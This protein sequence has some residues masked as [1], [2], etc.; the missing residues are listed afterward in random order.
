[1]S[2]SIPSAVAAIMA[3]AAVSVPSSGEVRFNRDVRPILSDRCYVCHGPDSVNRRAGLRFDQEQSAKSALKSG[4]FAIVPGKP[5]ESE[6]YRRIISDDKIKRMPPAYAGHAKLPDPQIA[7]L[8]E[9]I[10]EGAKY[11]QHWSFTPPVRAAGGSIDSIVRARLDREGLRM[12][13]EADKAT[14]IRRVTLDLTGLPPSIKDVD[15]FLHDSSPHAYERVVD[16]LLGSTEYAE[17]MAIRWLEAARYSDTNGYQSDGPREMWR[18][19]DWVIDAFAKNMPFDEFTIEQIA[20]DLLPNRTRDQQIATAFNRNH[21]TSAEGGIVEEEFRSGYVSDRAETTGTVWLGLTVGC[22]KCHDHKYD[23]ITQRDYYSLYSFFNNMHE[24]GLVYNFGNEEPMLKAPTPEMES[25]LASLDAAVNAKQTAWD[26]LSNR[27]MLE[28]KAWTKHA[29][30]GPPLDWAP[31]EGISLDRPESTHFD[32]KSQVELSPKIGKF[33]YQEPFSAAAWI[34]PES[35]NGAILSRGEDYLEGTGYYLLLVNGKLRFTATLRYTDISLRVETEEPVTLNQWQHVAVT[36]NGRRKASGVHLYINGEERKMNVLFD[37]FT[38]PYSSASMPFRIGGGAGFRFAGDIRG[39]RVYLSELSRAEASTLPIEK[40]IDELARQSQRTSAEG[41]KLHLCFLDQFASSEIKQT[42]AALAAALKER[43]KFY[44]SI[45]TVMVMVEGPVRQAHI[46]KRG[47][48]DAPGDPVSA[49]TPKFLTPFKAGWPANR[50][51]LARWLVDRGNPLTARVT[52]NRFWQMFFGIGLVK[53]TEDFGSQGDW[54]VQEE[55]LDWLAVEFMDSGWDVKH[56]L[57]TI[58]MSG[59]YRQTS[60]SS[61]EVIAKDPE[62]RLLA[63]GPR[64]RLSAEVIRDQALAVSGLLVDRVGG[65]SVKPYQPPKLWQE[66]GAGGYVEDHNDGLYRRS[67]Y[68]YWKRTVPPPYM[69]NFDSPTRETCSV[70]ESRT[71]TPLQALN[72]MNDTIFVEASR[73]LGE[74]MIR[75]GGSSEDSRIAFGYRTVLAR[76]PRPRELEV[77]RRAL[78]QF[79]RRFASDAKAAN[80]LLAI[81]ESKTAAAV[82]PAELAAYATVANM[83]LNLDETVTRQ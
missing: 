62:N 26:E 33:E 12:A 72:L 16:R 51:G 49:A 13:G 73:K 71:N 2:F 44:D 36:Y 17:R 46:L 58:V 54:P 37:E 22:A 9:W 21:R 4:E 43:Q 24:K 48:Y 56:I 39:V 65:P 68:T 67:L 19:R 32:G 82:A 47:A 18:W 76:D 70:R 55:L 50:L 8:R 77:V 15:A 74:L 59:T 63:R 3:F 31:A 14:L 53:T 64:V 83:I 57:K 23:P 7:T 34:R 30:V 42:H 78:E 35:P 38:Y 11:E 52:V 69:V 6:L 29:A 25:K 20:G 45:P 1:M 10:V 40:P 27:V 66:T 80:E 75:D 28:S 61:P 60:K 79:K 41:A 5:D 81:G